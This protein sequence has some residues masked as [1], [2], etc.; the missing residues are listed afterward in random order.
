MGLVYR[1][2]QLQPL[3]LH[4]NSTIALPTPSR[5]TMCL[6]IRTYKLLLVIYEYDP[7]KKKRKREEIDFEI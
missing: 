4:S 1:L 7:R 5:P 6:K 3:F 2:G